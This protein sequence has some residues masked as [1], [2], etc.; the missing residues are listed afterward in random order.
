MLV[1]SRKAGERICIG[2]DI[3]VE[4]VRIGPS[5]VRLGIEA[6]DAVNI[7]RSELTA[8]RHKCAAAVADPPR[9]DAFLELL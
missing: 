7:W 6:P 8:E 3:S 2:N 9:A 5:T 1:L 4:V